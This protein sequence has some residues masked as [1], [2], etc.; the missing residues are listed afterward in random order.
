MPK[1]QW[2][3]IQVVGGREDHI[4]RRIQA[5]CAPKLGEP[6]NPDLLQECFTPRFRT[7]HKI[8]G[9]WFDIE[10][11]LLP[12]YVIAVTTDPYALTIRLSRIPELT[13]IVTMGGTFVPLRDEDR[14]WL[15]E[16]TKQGDRV[17]PMSVA[18]KDGDTVI[19]TDGPLKGKEGQIT[20]INRSKSLAIVE[21]RAG[22][23]RITAHVGLAVLNELPKQ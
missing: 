13:R 15:E 22:S 6:P 23:V 21:L 19:I 17:V 3:V 8:Q 10:K 1:A 16:T 2:Y 5:E 7:Q 14:T 9:T 18:Y 20:R 4:V 11:L 12:G